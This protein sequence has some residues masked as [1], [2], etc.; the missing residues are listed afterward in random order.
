MLRVFIPDNNVLERKYIIGIILHEFLGL[1]YSLVINDSIINTDIILENGNT[2][3]IEDHF[4]NKFKIEKEYL[5]LSNI[6]SKIGFFNSDLISQEDIPIIFG[7]NYLQVSENSIICGL[8]IFASSFYML[9]RWEE[10]VIKDR[11]HHNRFL[12]KSSLA[13]KF[14]FLNRPIVNE[15]VELLW[16]MLVHLGVNQKRKE[17]KFQI[18][19]THDVDL[20]RLWWNFKGFAKNAVGDL[21]KRK[22]VTSFFLSIKNY[23]NKIF[24]GKDPFDTFNYLMTLSEKNNLKSHFFF[25]SGGTSNKDNYYKINHPIISKLMV[26]IDRRG[27]NIGFH[28][29]YNAYNDEHLFTKELDKLNTYSPQPIKSGREHFLRF[30]V[31]TTWQVWEKNNMEWDSS[32]SYADHEGFRCGVCYSF[33]VFNVLE[34]K[35]LNLKE[36]PLIVMDGSL[37]TY[38]NITVDEGYN[39]VNGLLQEVKKY[40]GEFVFLWHNSAFNTITWKPFQIIYEKILNENSN[41]YRS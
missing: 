35:Q 5:E 8:D 3:V 29:S 17:R 34:R 13:F 21:I 20:P 25:M 41:N 9:T 27:H 14:G 36:K 2:L 7:K 6:P 24:G 1:N 33:P 30:E 26:E 23:T 18:I 40:N 22:S 19:P 37:V 10:Y 12:S 32:M 11:D 16:N 15:Y 4:F 28:P 38:Q 31:P 39:K